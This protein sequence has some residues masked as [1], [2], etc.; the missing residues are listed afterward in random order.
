[1]EHK[2]L[3]RWKPAWVA[4]QSSPVQQPSEASTPSRTQSAV[5]HPSLNGLLGYSGSKS[6]KEFL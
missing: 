4:S 1:M 6:L 2:S 3:G 5:S